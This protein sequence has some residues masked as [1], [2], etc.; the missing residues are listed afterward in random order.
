MTECFADDTMVPT[1]FFLGK[2]AS[3]TSLLKDMVHSLEEWGSGRPV[4]FTPQTK[5]KKQLL[6]A[7]RMKC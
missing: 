6:V 4:I 2:E 3:V 5:A 1:T 7:S